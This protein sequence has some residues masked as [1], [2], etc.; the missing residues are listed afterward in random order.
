MSVEWETVIIDFPP[1]GILFV[2]SLAGTLWQAWRESRDNAESFRDWEFVED[3]FADPVFVGIGRDACVMSRRD[4]EG[5]QRERMFRATG[6]MPN[7]LDAIC[8]VAKIDTEAAE[9]SVMNHETAA[10]LMDESLDPVQAA[11]R[12]EQPMSLE[13]VC[14]IPSMWPVPWMVPGKPRCGVPEP[15]GVITMNERRKEG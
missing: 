6:S 15:Q 9:Q 11:S 2:L 14:T 3:T 8:K 10:S 12:S 1:Q 13:E 4:W 5:A 7:M